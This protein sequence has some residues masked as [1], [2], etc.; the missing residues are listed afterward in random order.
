MWVYVCGM[1]HAC[2]AKKKEKSSSR[3]VKVR[4]RYREFVTSNNL[5]LIDIEED[6]PALVVSKVFPQV[7]PLA[8][9]LKDALLIELEKGFWASVSRAPAVRFLRIMHS[10][11]QVP[12]DLLTY[13]THP[14][15][16]KEQRKSSRKSERLSTQSFQYTWFLCCISGLVVS[17]FSVGYSHKAALCVAIDDCVFPQLADD[18]IG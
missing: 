7:W 11:F 14:L 17:R 1:R 3:C 10:T 8:T 4:S 13:C 2:V 6:F 15:G 9:S 16:S 5:C 18:N 12:S